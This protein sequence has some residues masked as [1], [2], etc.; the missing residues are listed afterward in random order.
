MEKEERKEEGS[1]GLRN[2]RHL[3]ADKVGKIGN[4]L[5]I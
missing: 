5:P 4:R 1:S 3:N 2:Y